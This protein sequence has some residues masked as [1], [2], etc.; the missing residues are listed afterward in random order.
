MR[1][2][3]A[4]NVVLLCCGLLG[5]IAPVGV[6]QYAR[7]AATTGVLRVWVPA[8]S[9]GSEYWIYVNGRVMSAP[10]HASLAEQAV[11]VSTS[12]GWE[13]WTARGLVLRSIGDEGWD[14]DHSPYTTDPATLRALRLF[15][16]VDFRLPPGAYS[17]E[18]ATQSGIKQRTWFPFVFSGAWTD[19]EVKAGSTAQVFIQIPRAFKRLHDLRAARPRLCGYDLPASAPSQQMRDALH[20]EVQRY[21]SDPAVAALRDA[22]VS[23]QAQGRTT[24]IAFPN[25]QGGTHEFNGSQ[26]DLMLNSLEA[27]YNFPTQDEIKECQR[28]YPRFAQSYGKYGDVV[29]SVDE[30]LQSFRDFANELKRQPVIH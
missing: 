28:K 30:A 8:G 18:I 27:F 23:F 15:Q 25:A 29:S 10:P 9:I 7:A 11:D 26:V 22:K 5:L 2:R 14:K 1:I 6:R 19:R 17:V 24:R 16:A 21:T 4:R 12:N 13:T 20:R 3:R